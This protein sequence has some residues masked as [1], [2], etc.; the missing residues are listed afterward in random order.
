MESSF[1][2]SLPPFTR[3]PHSHL[4]LITAILPRRRKIAPPL[5][6]ITA[7]S[8]S[9]QAPLLSARTVSIS[10]S[11][12]KDKNADLSS[13][14]EEGFGVNG[15]GLLSISD[16]PEYSLLRKNLLHLSTRLANVSEDVKREL[17]DPDS[18]YSFGWSYGKEKQ[19]GKLDKLKASFFANPILDVPS[20]EPSNIQR[21][22]SYCRANIWPRTALPELEIAF[23]ALGKLILNVGLLL[24]HHC[25]RY[26]SSRIT[27]NENK[28]ILQ[29]LLPSRCHKGRLLYYFP[30]QNSSSALDDGSVSS[31]SG[32]HTDYASLT[33]LTCEMFTRDDVEIPCSDNA[34]GLY[35]MS[36]TGQVVKPEYGEDEIAYLV[37]ET[38]E[39]LS[40]HLLCA[41]PHC[42]RAPKGVEA[43]SVGRS[44]YVLFMQPNWDEKFNFS[45][46]AHIH[47]ELRHSNHP[48]T[49]GEYSER[50]HD[51]HY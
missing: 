14:I 32:W 30:T 2:S 37:G 40:R 34:A 49:Y 1:P 51:K 42:V 36:R 46:L 8:C 11:E 45:E 20:T 10:Y 7:A 19:D 6:T 47:E 27:T 28:E 13:K 17:E 25:D 35:I 3:S 16:V 39:I 12:L 22:P 15:L 44:T 33:G 21:Y 23:K 24:A 9:S 38:G 4:P 48:L 41:T 31:W 50:L 18:R 26:V 43:S 5:S 29:T